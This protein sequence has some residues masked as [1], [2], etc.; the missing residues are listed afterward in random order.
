MKSVVVSWKGLCREW[1]AGIVGLD[2]PARVAGRSSEEVPG[3]AG[4]SERPPEV[5]ELAGSCTGQHLY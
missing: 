1:V 3:W 5:V 2:V 4:R